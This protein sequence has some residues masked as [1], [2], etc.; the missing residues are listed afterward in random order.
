VIDST[1][2]RA[3]RSAVD[4]AREQKVD[5]GK[6]LDPRTRSTNIAF[7]AGKR[8]CALEI[9]AELSGDGGLASPP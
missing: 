2:M 6:D 9:A 1:G 8:Q 4:L 3:D 5:I 7:I